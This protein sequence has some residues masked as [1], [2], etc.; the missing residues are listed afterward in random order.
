MEWF[1]IT[2]CFLGFFCVVV[3]KVSGGIA[4][5][6]NNKVQNDKSFSKFEKI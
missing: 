4:D 5:N 6:D 1:A 3:I 2:V